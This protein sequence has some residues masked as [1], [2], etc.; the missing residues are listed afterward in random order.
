MN[1]PLPFELVEP[2]LDPRVRVVVD[3]LAERT[4]SDCDWND[5]AYWSR[6][7]DDSD[8]FKELTPTMK[9]QILVLVARNPGTVCHNVFSHMTDLIDDLTKE[10]E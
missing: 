7:L 5:A 4:G 10:D 3:V 2:V 8:F 6:R 9:R 1:A